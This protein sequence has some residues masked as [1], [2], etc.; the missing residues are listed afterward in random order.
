MSE[1]FGAWSWISDLV[2][3]SPMAEILYQGTC[4]ER[5]FS[6]LKY[7]VLVPPQ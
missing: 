6:T 2:I 5:S 1:S 4:F 7:R 3:E